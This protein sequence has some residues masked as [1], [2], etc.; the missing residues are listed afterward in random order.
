M[1]HP[2]FRVYPEFQLIPLTDEWIKNVFCSTQVNHVLM[3]SV[4]AAFSTANT[5][6]PTSAKMATH[7]FA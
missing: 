7:I 6:T 3:R 1:L 5:I 4:L 2:L